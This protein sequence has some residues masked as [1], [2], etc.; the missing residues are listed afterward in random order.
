MSADSRP[1]SAIALLIAS[2]AIESVVR[3]LGR[4]CGVSPT[5]TMQYLSVS[6]PIFFPHA[7]RGHTFATLVAS[8]LMSAA[9]TSRGFS[10]AIQWPARI[11]SSLRLRQYLRIGSARREWTVSHT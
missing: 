1:A 8:H 5:P 3:L 11:V 7:G 4:I 9:F 2:H 10:C 6:A